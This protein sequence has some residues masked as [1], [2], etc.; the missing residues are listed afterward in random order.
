[1][2]PEDVDRMAKSVPTVYNVCAGLPIQKLRIITVGAK[3]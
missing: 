1:M 3:S 2:G